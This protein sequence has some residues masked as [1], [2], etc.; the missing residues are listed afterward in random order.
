[1]AGLRIVLTSNIESLLRKGMRTGMARR[2]TLS[3]RAA[4]LP[5]GGRRHQAN[6]ARELCKVERT[7]QVLEGQRLTEEGMSG[8][9]EGDRKE[10]ALGD[11]G[12]CPSEALCDCIA[13][14]F[15]R[16]HSAAPSRGRRS[17]GEPRQE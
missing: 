5:N 16:G 12:P 2:S 15:A 1:M 6:E 10:G 7:I 17:A 11:S 14:R 3:G 8:G 9:S 13:Q 4:D